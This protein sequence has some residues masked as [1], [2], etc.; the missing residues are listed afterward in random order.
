[1]TNTL[2][3][4]EVEALA[5]R[6]FA[7]HGLA[8]QWRFGWDNARK[9]FGC[10]QYGSLTI[11]MSRYLTPHRDR[12]AVEQTLLHEIAHALVGAGHGHD[13]VWL[14]KARSLGYRGGRCSSD[15]VEA[16]A[17]ASRYVGTCDRCDVQ[18]PRHRMDARLVGRPAYRHRE[19]GGVIT[20]N[21]R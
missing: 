3:L 12:D 11:T 8:P 7:E 15:K 5:R 18:A 13:R 10:C 16:V 19:C 14:A 4:R 2:A 20:F 1:M 6:L 9:R 21:L 17:S